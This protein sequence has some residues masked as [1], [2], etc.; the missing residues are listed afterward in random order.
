M[1]DS[2]SLENVSEKRLRIQ[3]QPVQTNVVERVK[4]FVNVQLIASSAT[5]K[6]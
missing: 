1:S 5:C 3:V 4:R 2:R 6:G